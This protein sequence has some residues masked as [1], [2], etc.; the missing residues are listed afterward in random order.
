MVNKTAKQQ[1][2]VV[3]SIQPGPVTPAQRAGWRKWWSAR[4]AEA[5]REVV[6]E[7]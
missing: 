7:R 5:K 3:L 1:P 6:D 2:K 4:I